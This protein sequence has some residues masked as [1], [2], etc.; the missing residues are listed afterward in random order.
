MTLNTND[1]VEI[2]E[3]LVPCLPEIQKY[4]GQ[5]GRVIRADKMGAWIQMADG[6]E[7]YFFH[8][9]MEKV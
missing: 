5:R 7:K 8:A 1:T 4:A 9:E 6:A 2:H 3:R